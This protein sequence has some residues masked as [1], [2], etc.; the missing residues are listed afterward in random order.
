MTIDEAVSYALDN[1]DP[2]LLSGPIIR[3]G[4]AT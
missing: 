2:K 4:G 1:I 3:R